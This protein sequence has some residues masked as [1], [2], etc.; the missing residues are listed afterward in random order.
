MHVID[1]NFEIACIYILYYIHSLYSEYIY[2]CMC[3]G[4]LETTQKKRVSKKERRPLDTPS[5]SLCVPELVG[6]RLYQREIE[7]EQTGMKIFRWSLT[8]FPPQRHTL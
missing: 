6:F 7:A 3:F 5:P 2:R 8:P 4:F 1:G